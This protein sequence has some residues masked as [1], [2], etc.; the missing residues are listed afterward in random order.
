MSYEIAIFK[1][2]AH[3]CHCANRNAYFLMVCQNHQEHL[4]KVWFPIPNRLLSGCYLWPL[5]KYHSGSSIAMNISLCKVVSFWW[6]RICFRVFDMRTS[7]S[8]E[9]SSLSLRILLLVWFTAISILV[10]LEIFILL[11]LKTNE[12]C[13][14]YWNIKLQYFGYN[15]NL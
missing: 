4:Q 1:I 6:V 3:Q 10:N 7:S 5:Y 2:L 11:E 13:A 14:T 8:L 12:C 9:L 15:N